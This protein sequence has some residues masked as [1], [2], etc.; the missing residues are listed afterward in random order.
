MSHT[1]DFDTSASGFPPLRGATSSEDVVELILRHVDSGQLPPGSRLPTIR[2]ITDSSGLSFRTVSSAW[3]VLR[4]RGVIETRR[5]GG[6]F[7]VDPATAPGRAPAVVES[8]P[9]LTDLSLLHADRYLL[10][11]LRD[12]LESALTD[13]ALNAP[14]R[15]PITP[16]LLSSAQPTWPFEAESFLA[17]GGGAEAVL[18]SIVANTEPGDLVALDEPT[19]PG[20]LQRLAALG[21]RLIG[22]ELDEQGPVP[23]SLRIALDA[24]ARVYVFQVHAPF[25]LSG[26]PSSSRVDELGSLL[27]SADT[28][29]V[30]DDSVG[31]LARRD[32]ATFGRTLPEQVV[33]VRTYCRSYG[34]DLRTSVIGGPE[35]LL[36]RIA[37]A[38]SHGVAATSRILQ[39]ALSHLIDDPNAK[40]KL[41][42]AA[43]AY[44]ARGESLI[45]ALRAQGLE[46]SRGPEGH[47]AWVPVADEQRAL[48]RLA[49]EGILVGAGSRAFATPAARGYLRIVTLNLS[50]DPEEVAR[51]ARAIVHA[52]TSADPSD[53]YD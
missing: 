21:R 17:S 47:V 26:H 50:D 6:S 9:V 35:R 40:R 49:A 16:R 18:L 44:S 30:E 13:P 1:I 42:T 31:P 5:R 20:L 38:R 36:T 11:D 46:A 28:V 51:I 4:D 27:A 14:T 32:V 25:A 52:T 29:I 41:A 34:P 10:P 45:A 24:G 33:H 8:R 23:G 7:V 37:D 3:R 39:D 53:H 19:Q 12:A 43:Q 2:S 15:E 48:L 22:V